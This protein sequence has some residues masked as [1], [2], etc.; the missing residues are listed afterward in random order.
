MRKPVL[1]AAIAALFASSPAIAQPAGESGTAWPVRIFFDW[2]KPEL[3]SD[4]KATLD[5]LASHFNEF[6]GSL[7]LLAG[8]SDRS[9]P[10]AANIVSARRRAE[11]ARDYLISKGVPPGAMKILSLGEGRPLVPTEDGVREVQ[12]RRVE[13]TLQ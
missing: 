6:A 8:H 11:A 12:N 10:A 2:D 13:I 1:I 5:G 7:L 4:A 3:T 9:G